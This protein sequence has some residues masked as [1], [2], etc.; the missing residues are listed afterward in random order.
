MLPIFNCST[1]IVLPSYREG[2]PKVLIEAAAVGRP[3]VTSTLYSMPEVAGNAACL[4][5]P[6]SVS[7]IRAGI[8]KVINEP[9]Y[10]AALVRE[11]FI[12]VERFR[13]ELIAEKY[14]NLYR[15]MLSSKKT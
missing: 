4:V 3:V 10:R 8:L 13:V 12:N 6:Y 11:G 2:L 15:N 7:S 1:I 5:D 14:A 9:E